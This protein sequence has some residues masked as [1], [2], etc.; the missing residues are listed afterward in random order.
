MKFECDYGRTCRRSMFARYTDWSGVLCD[1]YIVVQD[2]PD[3][4]F[5]KVVIVREVTQLDVRAGH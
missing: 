5:T 1:S 4:V 2:T 3:D